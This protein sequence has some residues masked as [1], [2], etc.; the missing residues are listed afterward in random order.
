MCGLA[1][2]RDVCTH[3]CSTRNVIHIGA[4]FLGGT[5]VSPGGHSSAGQ[6][7]ACSV[8][9]E[10]TGLCEYA[11]ALTLHTCYRDKLTHVHNS[12]TK[13]RNVRKFGPCS[14]VIAYLTL[15]AVEQRPDTFDIWVS[16]KGTELIW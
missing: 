8:L 9:E 15:G 6:S 4:K 16:V 1:D 11:Q 13:T 14:A 12:Q 5:H 7:I 3:G 10:C 2:G